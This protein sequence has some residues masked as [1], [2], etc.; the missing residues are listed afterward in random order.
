MPACK[1]T[2]RELEE[3]L[4]QACITHGVAIA[5]DAGTVGGSQTRL[6]S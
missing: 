5:F 6:H 2:D 4:A 3:L 1:A